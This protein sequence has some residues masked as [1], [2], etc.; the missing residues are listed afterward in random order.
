MVYGHISLIR[1]YIRSLWYDAIFVL[2]CPIPL[3]Q[4]SCYHMNL[5][6]IKTVLIQYT[7]TC[8][9]VSPPLLGV[10]NVCC[11]Q[12]GP[13]PY[14]GG[15]LS[16]LQLHLHPGE[17]PGGGR[18][19]PALCLQDHPRCGGERGCLDVECDTYMDNYAI[20]LLFCCQPRNYESLKFDLLCIY[21][22]SLYVPLW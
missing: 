21:V 22:P 4:C 8:F 7:N 12:T 9:T 1:W 18:D 14:C 20:L 3:M 6:C 17:E 19:I 16:L 13:H 15:V 11:V 10:E 5:N 2:L